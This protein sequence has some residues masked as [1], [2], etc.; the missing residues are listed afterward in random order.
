MLDS[1]GRQPENRP[2]TPKRQYRRPLKTTGGPRRTSAKRSTNC[3]ALAPSP[4]DD[5][6]PQQATALVAIMRGSNGRMDR[7]QRLHS[8]ER[9]DHAKTED[10]RSE[11]QRDRDRILDSPAF[12]RLA[13][14]TQVIS[15]SAE[16]QLTHNRMTHSLKVAQVGRR[17]AERLAMQDEADNL[18]GI[19]PDVVEAAALAHDLGH[20]PF[21]HIG[22]E[23]LDRCVQCMEPAV[24][25]EN[26]DADD[27]FLDGFEGNPQSFRTVTKLARI[28]PVTYGL[29]LTAATR[30]AILKYPHLRSSNESDLQHKK[31][32]AYRSEQRDFEQARKLQPDGADEAQSVEAAIMDWSDDVSYST[33]DLEDFW[34][35]N[36]I[37]FRSL[38]D[39][40]SELTKFEADAGRRLENRNPSRYSSAEWTS[41]LTN[42][43]NMLRADEWERLRTPFSGSAE[44]RGTIHLLVSNLITKYMSDVEL[45]TRSSPLMVPDEIWHEVN[46]VKELTWQYVINR[47]ALT[48]VQKAHKHVI[49]TLYRIMWEMC[50]EEPERIP[51][52]LRAALRAAKEDE[53]VTGKNVTKRVRARAVADFIAIST[54]EQV[55]TLYQQLTGASREAVLGSWIS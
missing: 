21:G 12:R 43:Q 55:I 4:D 10:P 35:A 20:P 19:D 50:D 28:N 39:P 52:R 51:S 9:E 34:R 26:A 17:L 44:D 13:G 27:R 23:V 7:D 29:D 30:N 36:L 46:L 25:E 42:F 5:G 33:H 6:L 54:E 38:T 22:D 11:A 2:M 3:D 15:P 47:P 37:D 48:V 31:W 16:L 53:G 41:A 18:G 14:I 32:G 40:T 1:A 49:H 8:G 24:A 45:G